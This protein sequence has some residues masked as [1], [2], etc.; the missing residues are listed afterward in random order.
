M[1]AMTTRRIPAF[2]NACQALVPEN[3]KK[4]KI[5][6]TRHEALHYEMLYTMKCSTSWKDLF[7]LCERLCIML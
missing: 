2:A 1:T 5:Y 6:L 3:N 4:V 7:T